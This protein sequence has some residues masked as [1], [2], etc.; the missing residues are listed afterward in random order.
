MYS[1][2]KDSDDI[3][4]KPILTG[5]SEEIDKRSRIP[6][7]SND[8]EIEIVLGRK[9]NNPY[10]LANMTSAINK[11]Y[12]TNYSNIAATHK[13]VK[14]LPTTHEHLAVL[15]EWETQTLTPFFS[16]PLDYEVVETIY[17]TV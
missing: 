12:K 9:R 6:G 13:Y 2:A 1:C 15:E 17:T 14:F 5:Q 7:P 16:Y 3:G 8:N 10:T 11:I 4:Q